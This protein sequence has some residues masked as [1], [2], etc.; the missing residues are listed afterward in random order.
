MACKR[1][2]EYLIDHNRITP[3]QLQQAL[4]LQI[5]QP[6]GDNAPVGKVLYQLGCIEEQDIAAALERQQSDR[7][8]QAWIAS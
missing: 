7:R 8:R 5:L 2:G 1:F 3:A 4:E 6:I